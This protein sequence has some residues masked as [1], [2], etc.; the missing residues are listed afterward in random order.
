MEY[1]LNI[2]IPL[3]LIESNSTFLE[4]NVSKEVMISYEAISYVASI[5]CRLVP[6]CTGSFISEV[7]VLT[8]AHCIYGIKTR[9][10]AK[11]IDKFSVWIGIREKFDGMVLKIKD[12]EIHPEFVRHLSLNDIGL[13]LVSS[14]TL[15]INLKVF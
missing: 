11:N 10:L 12:F 7:H 13:L 2:M 6:I 3:L 1:Y 15:N 9:G 5:R 14:D 8:S 4:H